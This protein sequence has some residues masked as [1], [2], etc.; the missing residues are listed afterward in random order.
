[1]YQYIWDPETGGLLLT[2]EQSKFSKEPRPVYYRELDILGFD[3]YWNYPKDD[4]APIMWAEAN[5][6]IYHGK[7]VAK[8]KGG[9][10]YTA[11]EICILDDPEP[12]GM[13]LSLVDIDSMV[14]KNRTLLEVLVQETIQDV[15]NT[16]N[17][18]KRKVDL[19]YV[20]FSGGKDSVVTLDIVQRALPHNE[21]IVIFGDTHMEFSDTYDVIE[22]IK[23]WC[24]RNG[25]DFKVAQSE[26]MPD[27]TWDQFGPPAQ[28]MRWCCSVHKTAP[29]IILL[30]ELTDKPDFRGMAMMGVRAEESVSRSRYDKINF[31]TKHKGQYDFYPILE[32]N[33]AELFL[34]IFQENLI[35]NQTY[36]KGNSRAG[37]LVCPMTSSK[38]AWFREQTYAGDI[39][40]WHTTSF[41][42]NMII[43]KTIADLSPERQRELM[44]M[45]V[46]KSRHN[47]TK[48]SRP[49]DVYHEEIGN[50]SITIILD[51]LNV[52]WKEWLKTIGDLNFRPNGREAEIFCDGEQYVLEYWVD[53]SKYYFRVDNIGTTQKNIYFV[54]WLKIVLRKSAYCITCRVCEANCPNGFIHMDQGIVRIDD[55]CVKCKKCYEVSEGCIVFS[56]HRLPKEGRT[57]KGSINEYKSLGVRYEWVKE[58]LNKKDSFWD[59]NGLGSMMI[60]PLKSFLRDSGIT[61][62]NKI[63]SFGELVSNIGGDNSI[64][65][66]LMMC[67]ATY[68]SPQFNWWI[69]HVEFDHVYTTEELE[70][71]LD[72]AG[73]TESSKNHTI[74]S[75]KNIFSSNPVLAEE[76]GMGN[77]TIET[78]GR[79]SYLIDITRT[80]WRAPDSRVI[81][82]SLFK[83]A[84][85]C[86]DYYQFTLETLL[87]DSVERDGVSPTKIFGLDRDSMVRILNGLSVNYPEFISASFNLD[88]DSITLHSDKTSSDVLQLF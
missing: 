57:M 25:I 59:D 66:A 16:Y 63:T 51:S 44:E 8:L 35:L 79:N 68:I 64:A 39:D 75:F 13:Q 33:S 31:G 48:L 27:Y 12:N 18:Y 22:Q 54:S 87:D 86:G 2:S 14:N 52:D 3:R 60:A 5:N 78:K 26:F 42:D 67:N 88:L 61:Q 20:A 80:P 62:K 77:P 50:R 70:S 81:L 29:Q 19:F 72:E 55:S 11:P 4:S 34:Y 83:F 10:I 71:M 76:L 1:M 32:W 37:C 74:L 46:W 23:D 49:K 40:D 73:L 17:K 38:N 56:S 24:K 9:S 85:A 65:W 53:Q 43:Q 21:F 30:R 15:Y 41:Y 47:G 84:E 7:T 45:E 28:K 82:Y 6:Y 69:M 36:K 58:Y